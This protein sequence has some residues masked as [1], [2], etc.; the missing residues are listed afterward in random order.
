MNNKMMM[1]LIGLVLL[2]ILGGFVYMNMK[3]GSVEDVVVTPTTDIGQQ[4]VVITEEPTMTIDETTQS[5]TND[6]T[7]KEF[8]VDGSNFKFSVA[9]MKVNK[10]DTVKVT[11]NNVEGM[12][13]WVVDEFNARTK[14]IQAGEL[15][16]ITFVADQT[17]TFEYYCSVGKH[18][19]MGMVGNLIVE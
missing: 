8:N 5:V 19:Q 10:G 2:V 18:R 16:T 11:F 1:G 13:D 17:G 6:Q 12:H 3:S 14:Q 9:E 15:E 4:P 7:V